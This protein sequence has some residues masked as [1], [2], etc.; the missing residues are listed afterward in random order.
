MHG[1]FGWSQDAG[2]IIIVIEKDMGKKED[3]NQCFGGPVGIDILL[4]DDHLVH[5]CQVAI[6]VDFHLK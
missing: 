3:A 4:W 1:S 5:E 6:F 2:K